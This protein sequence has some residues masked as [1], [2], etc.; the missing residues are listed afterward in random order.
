MLFSLLLQKFIGHHA[1]I[2]DVRKEHGFG[3][4][5]V[6]MKLVVSFMKI[7][8]LFQTLL[9]AVNEQIINM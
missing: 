9:R 8:K 3:R 1:G 5:C 4:A 6:D 7:W 2:V